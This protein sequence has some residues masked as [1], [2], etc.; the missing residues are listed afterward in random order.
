MS[1]ANEPWHA[2]VLRENPN[3]RSWTPEA[4]ELIFRTRGISVHVH[5]ERGYAPY[6]AGDIDVLYAVDPKYEA[7][8]N[9][10]RGSVRRTINQ[11]PGIVMPRYSIPG[12][13]EPFAQVRPFKFKE[14]D[15]GLDLSRY[16]IEEDPGVFKGT[17]THKHLQAYRHRH[18]PHGA[19]VVGERPRTAYRP[20]RLSRPWLIEHIAWEHDQRG[21]AF[22]EF[23]G[24]E[25]VPGTEVHVHSISW[26]KH[27]E[28]AEYDLD[29]Q[30]QSEPREHAH[31]HR[32]YAKY[33]YVSKGKVIDQR[34]ERPAKVVDVHPAAM[35][36][37]Q[38][39]GRRC[40]FA[41][42]GLL[43]NDAILTQGEPVLNCGSVTLW[44]D[45]ALGLFATEFLKRFET[46][47]IVP[48]SDWLGNE[49]VATQAMRLQDRLGEHGVSA[50]IAAPAPTCSQQTGNPAC[51]HPHK[52]SDPSGRTT[53]EHKNGVDDWLGSGRSLDQMITWEYPDGSQLPDIG[54]Q[55][56]SRE[57]DR[58]V[59]EYLWR[60]Q[61]PW[62]GRVRRSLR[63]IGR[64]LRLDKNAVW[65]AMQD[66]DEA[67][68]IKHV[69]SDDLYF[70]Y[71]STTTVQLTDQLRSA[72]PRGLGDLT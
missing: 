14:L 38:A 64:N 3:L 55:R 63:D 33:V 62:S 30:Q 13:P 16:G 6:N 8:T 51:I 65:R 26:T 46:V 29:H 34:A 12:A 9:S 48:D 49:H 61:N 44:D 41:L 7:L 52:A 72:I 60:G 50:I 10:E 20:P 22:A 21:W 45:P 27:E 43:K 4:F 37:I 54:R 47:V 15:P 24:F 58:R 66:L 35:P 42:E 5:E 71:D 56:R 1:T 28:N 23:G 39:G 18:T 36:L 11:R 17:W 32:E 69:P 40:F 19:L 25:T 70:G 67:G 57:R 31:R 59:L 2:Q 68:A 53:P